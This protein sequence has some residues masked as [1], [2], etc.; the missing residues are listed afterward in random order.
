M[1]TNHLPTFADACG[2]IQQQLQ[3]ITGAEVI[4]IEQSLGRVLATP[5]IAPIPLQ[6]YRNSAMD[7]Y[8]FQ[9][10]TLNNESEHQLPIIGTAYAGQPFQGDLKNGECVRIMTGALLPETTDSVVIQENVHLENNQIRFS[11]PIKAGQNVRQAGEDYQV[12]ETA[13]QA[14]QRI[15][16]ADLGVLAALGMTAIEVQRPLRVCYFTSG[17]ELKTPGEALLSGQ[18]YDSNRYALAGLLQRA[19]ITA[20][21]GGKL[22]DS[23]TALKQ[24]LLTATAQADAIITCGAVSVGEADFIGKLLADEGNVFFSKLAIKPGKPLHFAKFNQSWFFGLP[25]NPISAMVTFLLLVQPALFQLMGAGWLEPKRWPATLL[26]PL[27]K[28]PGR[29]DFQRGKL[30]QQADG[31]MVVSSTGHQGS[32][33]LRSMSLANCFILL[34]S[35]S[36]NLPIGSIVQTLAFSELYGF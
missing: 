35:E 4:P 5:V 2:I 17:D 12:S 21:Y 18:I 16:P 15:T 24:Q 1:S 33:L 3:P 20:H 10:S 6:P 26:S 13:L 7:G 9:A 19:G 31:S 29:L 23:P 32:H 34:P 8:A 11:G 36:D 30:T 25:G 27:Q 28:R 14:G 22:P